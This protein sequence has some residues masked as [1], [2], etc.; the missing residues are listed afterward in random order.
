MRSWLRDQGISRLTQAHLLGE[1]RHLTTEISSWVWNQMLDD[2]R[3]PHGITFPSKHGSDY[4][5]YAIYLRAIGD[6]KPL[7]SE[8][9]KTDDGSPIDPP[10]MNKPLHRVAATFEMSCH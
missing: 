9:T 1:D 3:Y 7:S 2:G 5:C 6:G 10:H 8:P 4:L